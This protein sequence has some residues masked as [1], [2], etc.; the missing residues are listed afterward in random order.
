MSFSRRSFLAASAIFAAAA[1]A[2]PARRIKAV[3]FD[4]FVIFDPRPVAALAEQLYPG[5]GAALIASWRARQF[6]YTWLRNSIGRYVPFDQVTEDALVYAAHAEKLELDAGRRRQL[7]ASF[8][9]MPLWPDVAVGLSHLKAAG[10]R[11]A[12]L[13]NLT[14]AMMREGLAAAGVGGQFDALI[15]TDRARLYKPAPAAYQLGA[16]TL[17]LD[18]NAIAFAASAGWDAAGADAFGYPTIWINRGKL[19]DEE[20]GARGYASGSGMSELTAFVINS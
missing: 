6:D 11:L 12:M 7:L 2:D 9:A 3:A 1:H 10:L 20:L 17:G 5:R 13:A 16:D 19:P 4:G 18:K 8:E 15:S 14:P